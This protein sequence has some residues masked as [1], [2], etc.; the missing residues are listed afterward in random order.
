MAQGW[1]ALFSDIVDSLGSLA[2]KPLETAKNNTWAM[3]TEIFALVRLGIA[4][5]NLLAVLVDEIVAW[6]FVEG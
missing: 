6:V 3:I 2:V 4:F 1:I 5:A